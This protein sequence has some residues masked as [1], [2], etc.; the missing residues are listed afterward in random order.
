ML[1]LE[2][3][4]FPNDFIFY[5]HYFLVM[6]RKLVSIMCI[7]CQTSKAINFVSEIPSKTSI[8]FVISTRLKIS[9]EK[10]THLNWPLLIWFQVLYVAY[11]CIHL[12]N[13]I[14]WIVKNTTTSVQLVSLYLQVQQYSVWFNLYLNPP[15]Y[16]I[17]HLYPVQVE[18]TSK[19]ENKWILFSLSK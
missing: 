5:N 11:R 16:I 7:K 4:H 3:H 8:F 18:V 6:Q 10:S 17:W 15:S 2:I 14:L 9:A 1:C 19:S 13:K 12:K